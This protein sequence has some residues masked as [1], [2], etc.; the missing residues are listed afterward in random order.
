MAVGSRAT[1][2][3]PKA[4][5]DGADAG[6]F[7]A[8]AGIYADTGAAVG[9]GSRVTV[10]SVSERSRNTNPY[11][12]AAAAAAL[13]VAARGGDGLGPVGTWNG[14]HR[15]GKGGRGGCPRGRAATQERAYCVA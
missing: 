14:M 8:D 7:S 11:C 3:P 2:D 1:S 6:G 15:A 10:T 4:K 9:A 5:A 12:A 13:A